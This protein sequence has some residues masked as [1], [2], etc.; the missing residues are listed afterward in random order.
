MRHYRFPMMSFLY[1]SPFEIRHEAL[2]RVRT[3][4]ELVAVPIAGRTLTKSERREIETR[5]PSVLNDRSPM[6]IDGSKVILVFDRL[7]Y[8]RVGTR[9]LNF[10]QREDGIRTDADFVG[11]IYSTPTAGY[12][13]EAT[14]EWTVFPDPVT[15]VPGNAIDAA[16]PL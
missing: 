12:A 2:I 6:T 3:A 10:I 11:L 5:L 9:G 16:G 1:A 15:N 14:V 13:Q 4:A 7:S 8:M